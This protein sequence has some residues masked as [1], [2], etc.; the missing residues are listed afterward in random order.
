MVKGAAINA[1]NVLRAVVK[2]DK[3]LEVAA[4]AVVV[5]LLC[6]FSLMV[7]SCT[8]ISSNTVFVDSVF[9]PSLIVT[10]LYPPAK[11]FELPDPTLVHPLISSFI[12][13]QPLPLT[14]TELEPLAIGA[15]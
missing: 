3:K 4:F 8:A 12:L 2:S 1:R 10:L 7:I 11:T 9:L 13:P 14:I 5:V 15:E 6:T